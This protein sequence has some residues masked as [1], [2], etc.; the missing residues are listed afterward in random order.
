MPYLLCI[1]LNGTSEGLKDLLEQL[2]DEKAL[3][4]Y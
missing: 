2:G 3:R 4:S 1:N